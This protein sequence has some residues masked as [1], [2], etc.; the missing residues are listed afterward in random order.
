MR[1]DERLF[2]RFTITDSIKRRNGC[3]NIYASISIVKN[4]SPKSFKNWREE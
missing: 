3:E 1:V 2:G 4:G